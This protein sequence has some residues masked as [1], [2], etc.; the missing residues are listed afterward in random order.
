MAR[1]ILF[2]TL[3]VASIADELPSR[4]YLNLA[5]IKTMVAA[6]E[7]EAQKRSVN[8]TICIVDESGNLLFLQKADR[9]AFVFVHPFA[10]KITLGQKRSRAHVARV[11]RLREPLC[12]FHKI[13]LDAG[14]I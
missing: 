14:A 9:L 4:K 5:A 10:V 8:V 3:A 7:A 1:L 2:L 13:T 12:R 6:A 11:V